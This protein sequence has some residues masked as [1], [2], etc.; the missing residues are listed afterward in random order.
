MLSILLSVASLCLLAIAELK[1][2]ELA[3]EKE[4]G[5]QI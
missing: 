1:L 4:L 2:A 3:F 5:L